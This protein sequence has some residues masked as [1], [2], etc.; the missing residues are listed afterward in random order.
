MTRALLP[1]PGLLTVTDPEHSVTILS[2]HPGQETPA[3]LVTKFTPVRYAVACL[4]QEIQQAHA[5]R[6]E[7]Q[8]AADARA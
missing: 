8:V 5:A 3:R 6:L 7:A 2:Q 4:A 1:A